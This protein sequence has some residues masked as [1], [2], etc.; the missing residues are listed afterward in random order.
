M[1]LYGLSVFADDVGGVLGKV[2][3]AA[4][5][6][7]SL[8]IALKLS[9][10]MIAIK[11]NSQG[12]RHRWIRR[13]L[14]SREPDIFLSWSQIQ[15]YFFED[16]RTY[17][18]FQMRLP[19]NQRYRFYR[20]TIWPVKDDFERFRAAFPK[21]IQQADSMDHEIVLG[22]TIYEEPWFRK[23]MVVMSAMVIL[24]WGSALMDWSNAANVWTYGAITLGL[25]FY[26]IQVSRKVK[27]RENEEGS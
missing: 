22:K 26:W 21:L 18:K 13:F 4:H 5:M 23:I 14:F 12:F 2:L 3:F 19:N 10:A 27:G 7:L 25:A 9:T 20:Q 17:V 16:D 1:G 15:E 24:L 6:G 8:F 11:V